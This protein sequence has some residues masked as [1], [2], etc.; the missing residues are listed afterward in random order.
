[1]LLNA[2]AEIENVGS[3]PVFLSSQQVGTGPDRFLTMDV[4]VHGSQ[5]II[6]WKQ[7]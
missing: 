6:S 5:S 1:M 7:C 4:G 3:T 2:F